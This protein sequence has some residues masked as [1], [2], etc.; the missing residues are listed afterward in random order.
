MTPWRPLVLGLLV[1]AA[2]A[3]A[4]PAQQTTVKSLIGDGYA[5]VST[6]MTPIGPALFLQKADSLY[7]CF[8]TE[9]LDSP[10][11]RTN[12]CKAVE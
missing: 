12:Y 4:A 1:A 6:F 7:V 3:T 10:V 11:L 9:T 5:V 8:V 2:A